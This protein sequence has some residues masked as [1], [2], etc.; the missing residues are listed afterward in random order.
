MECAN[1]YNK[2]VE[3]KYHYSC[4][5]KI[6]GYSI[7]KKSC[8]FCNYL[9]TID[10]WNDCKHPHHPHVIEYPDIT[11]CSDFKLGV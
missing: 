8:I 1:C 10:I 4:P 11:S 7:D 5:D 6:C 9:K 2:L 3:T